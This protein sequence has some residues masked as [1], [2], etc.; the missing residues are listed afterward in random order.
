MTN[1]NG[2]TARAGGRLTRRRLLHAAAL[3]ATGLTAAWAAGCT[4]QNTR[5]LGTVVTVPPRPAATAPHAGVDPDAS[6]AAGGAA[7]TPAA[8]EAATPAPNRGG[9]LRVDYA[10]DLAP[11]ALPH[12]L[13]GGANRIAAR[14]FDSL[15]EYDKARTPQPALAESWEFAPDSLS[16]TLKL[17]PALFHS[18][19]PFSAEDVKFNLARVRAPEV[20]SPLQGYAA[21]IAAVE[22]PDPRTV[23]LRFARPRRTILDLLHALLIGDRESLDRIKDGGPIVGT[24]PFRFKEWLPRDRFTLERNPH[25]WQPNL[26]YL[27]AVKTRIIADDTARLIDFQTGKSDVLAALPL[28][29]ANDL[30]QSGLFEIESPPFATAVHCLGADLAFSPLADARVRQALNCTIDRPLLVQRA[31]SGQ[32]RATPLLWQ[33]GSPAYAAEQEA[34]YQFDPPKAKQLLDQAGWDAATVV[35]VFTGPEQTAA[36]IAALLQDDC[37]KIGVKLAVQRLEQADFDRRL[38]AGSFRGLW[39]GTVDFIR[40]Q[41]ATPFVQ[42]AALRPGN[43]SHYSSARYTALIDRLL[44]ETDEAKL[45]PAYAEITQLLLD[46]SFVMPLSPRVEPIARQKILQ[47]FE[48]NGDNVLRTELVS[49]TRGPGTGDRG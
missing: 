42:A 23:V 32:G 7:T 31:L 46:E 20:G 2:R 26:P 48:W 30:V 28:A 6:P 15:L 36:A 16:L 34:A 21:M 10:T 17:R 29:S 4:E 19:R 38:A 8:G 13:A 25:Y 22:T 45:K 33:P 12:Q 41:P 1:A 44:D 18:G 43:P 24:G 37:E 5:R 47:G 9:T 27:D 14:V 49:F 35:P 40:L 3:G 11:A 39:L